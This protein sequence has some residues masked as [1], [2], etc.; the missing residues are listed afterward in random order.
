LFEQCCDQIRVTD[1]TRLAVSG[2]RVSLSFAELDAWANQLARLLLAQGVCP[3]ER[4]ALLFEYPVYSY[5]AMLAVLKVH[6]AYVPLDPGFPAERIALIV[7]D[8][9]ADFV[10]C[11]ESM[12]GRFHDIPVRTVAL[13]SVQE[14]IEQESGERLT[15]AETGV[16]VDELAYVIY[17]SGSTGT[18]KGVA[19]DHPSIVNFVRVAAENYGYRP[20]DRVYQGLTI[21]FDFSVEEI[22]VPLLAGATLVPKPSGTTS[23]VGDD[24]GDFL[25]QQRVTALACVPTLLASL[26]TDLPD[27]RFL[28][29]S[30]EACPQDL[31]A[32]WWSP[33]RRFLN[34]YGPTEATV[35][36]TWALLH[37]EQPV[38]LGE[39]L[40][41]YTVAILDPHRPRVL[42][43]G[44]T[45]EIAIAGIGLAREY[46]NQPDKTTDVFVPDFLDLPHNPSGRLYRTGDLG[47]LNSKGNIEYLGRIDTQVKIRGYRVE[48]TEIESALLGLKG[49]AQAVVDTYQPSAHASEELVAY[50]ST[51]NET[52]HL[53]PETLHQALREQLPAYMVPAYFEHLPTIPLMPSGKADR[54]NLPEPTHRYRTSSTAY[55]K[56]ETTT[57]HALAAALATVLDLPTTDVSTSAHFFTDLGTNSLLLARFRSRLRS[58]PRLPTLSVRQVY[59]N[60]TIQQLAAILDNNPHTK[61]EPKPSTEDMKKDAAQ[62]STFQYVLCGA[63]QLLLFTGYL[64]LMIQLFTPPLDWISQA[65]D[66]PTTYL[67]ALPVGIG[68]FATLCLAPIAV[69][70]VLIGRWTTDEIP[71]WGWKYVRFWFV[72]ALMRSNP[73]MLFLGTPLYNFYLRAL[74]AKIGPSVL[75]LTRHIPIC[76]DLLTIG[77]HSVV[78]KDAY[79]NG[80]RA[81][82]GIIQPGT[83]TLGARSFVGEGSILDIN[84]E[85]GDHG[86]LAHASALHSGCSIPAG[87]H[88]HGSPA[89]RTHVDYLTVEPAH[90]S[91]TRK[92]RTCVTRLLP[93]LVAYLPLSLGTI[94]DSVL[95]GRW[96][97]TTAPPT[98]GLFYAETAAA[99]T[100]TVLFGIPLGLL[101]I[102]TVPRL[103]AKAVQP[104]RTYPLYSFQYGM[105][106][107][108]ARL[109]NFKFYMNL[110]GDSIYIPYYLRALGYKLP[111]LVQTGSN[112][113]AEQQHE[114]PFLTTIGS[115]TMVSDGLSMMNAS[116]SSTSFRVD[117]G[118]IGERN[119]LG[120]RV[121]YP[122]GGRTGDNVL[123]ATKVMV[124]L[125]GE[126]QENTGLLGS[127]AF[128]I[129]RSVERDS[130]AIPEDPQEMRRALRSKTR[131]NTATIGIF[132]ATRWLLL[133]GAFTLGLIDD[134]L[135]T[136]PAGIAVLIEL[137]SM[138]LGLGYFTLLERAAFGFRRL[139]PR[140]CSIYERAFWRHERLWKLLIPALTVLDGT[141]F[142]NLLWRLLGV[143]IGH[144][145][146]D[147]G[148]SMPEKTLVTIGDGATLN[149]GSVIQAHSLED[150]SFKSDYVVVKR[151]A[152]L[153]VG[154]FIHY[155]TTIGEHATVEADSFLMKGEEVAPNQRWRGNP[156]Q[157]LVTPDRQTSL[158]TSL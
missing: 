90:V 48:L 13:D 88:W 34:A 102:T 20:G 108:I 122:A 104:G 137:G 145:V 9:G 16:P 41:S 76:T 83:V 56:P 45:G 98:E 136:D 51:T 73:L 43:P 19:I 134:Y 18:P 28:L 150:G 131:H 152:T 61:A 59:E 82:A 149:A 86:Q 60:P 24:L 92:V 57:E 11:Q 111:S 65:P 2:E 140:S 135:P 125:D 123:L 33:H 117:R 155:G 36:A 32:R 25:R 77:A 52:T 138:F 68:L 128:L 97:F 66:V 153:G 121:H 47:R 148:C 67:R 94:D 133:F 69:K 4:V 87:T 93:I 79:L 124:P 75:V 115:G 146:F 139:R 50:Y 141:P 147:D 116:Y 74:G 62:V 63:S 158:A 81:E 144:K 54:N 80:Y 142:K 100:A 58:D 3:G 156:A 14:K 89:E 101:L 99:A 95:E 110:F 31:V 109:T 40:P 39:P 71:V 29:V 91:R 64:Y 38:T 157:E 85:I 132:L 78:R 126:V 143:R 8:S 21:A 53:N 118:H 37:P 35:T 10:L 23:L 22:W 119:F 12:V 107:L 106:R 42:A 49:I 5:V 103:L 27:L 17:T 112:F 55:T 6:A 26:D 105:H 114:N 30:G 84:T 7:D 130:T 127:P 70:W 1:D 151:G 154:A 129:P 46:L 72:K 96:T 120:N 113:G 44:E 15:D